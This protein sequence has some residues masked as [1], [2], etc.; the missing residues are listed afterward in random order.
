MSDEELRLNVPLS[1]S[2]CF[3]S[4]A[5]R[6]RERKFHQTKR[7]VK[8]ARVKS[9]IKK[10]IKSKTRIA[11]NLLQETSDFCDERLI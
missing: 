1:P 9:A 5:K 6:E 2:L 4:K 8:K 3:N 11:V 7:N 10:K